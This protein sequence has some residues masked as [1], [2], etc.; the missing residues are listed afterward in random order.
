MK[1]IPAGA[2]ADGAKMG[3]SGVGGACADVVPKSTGLV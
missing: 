1:I 3:G 2:G